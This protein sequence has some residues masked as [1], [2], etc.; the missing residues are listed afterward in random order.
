MY[1]EVY[2]SCLRR[3]G[4]EHTQTQ[5]ALRGIQLL[6]LD[7]GRLDQARQVAR[8]VFAAYERAAARPEVDPAVLTEYAEYAVSVDPPDLRT[9]RRAVQVARRAVDATERKDYMSLRALGLAQ[10]AAAEPR[11]AIASLREALALPEGARSWTTEEQLVKLLEAQGTPG[12][13]ESFLRERV[14]RQR[15]IRGADDRYIA[16]TLRL[17]ARHYVALDHEDEAERWSR[18]SLAQLL[19]TVPERSWEVARAQWELGALL[20][21]R[22]AFPE[23]ESLLVRGYRTLE[24]D[25]DTPSTRLEEIRG[26][27]VRMYAAWNR[28]E[29]AQAWRSRTIPARAPFNG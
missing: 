13:V 24:A 28:G 21:E 19:K 8:R 29:A 9:P 3:L 15:Q 4:P 7:Q 12:E 6:R 5:Q 16:K 27:I 26:W 18:E 14:E 17:L 10:I 2:E 23:A 1:V 11:D 22:R 25:P 20:V